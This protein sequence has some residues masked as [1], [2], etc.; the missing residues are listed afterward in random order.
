MRRSILA[1]AAAGLFA[2]APVRLGAAAPRTVTIHTADGRSVNALLFDADAHPAAAVV[3]VPMYGRTKEDWQAVGQRLSEANVTAL[4]LDLPAIGAPDDQRAVS[5]W[6]ADVRA[7]I[8]LLA[9]MPDVR[10]SAIGVLGASHGATIAALEA[11]GDTRVRAL[12]LVS[13]S[14]DYRGLRIESAMRQYGKRPALLVASSHDPYAA[15]SSRELAKDAPGPRELQ[16]SDVT[17][18]GTLLL[19]QDGDLV[20]AIVDWFRRTLG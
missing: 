18:H 2:I 12:A 15:R 3:L 8:D 1:V 20:R 17:A 16:M 14:L 19:S 13:P 11:G 7:A 6:T 4:A 5:T 10:A 9:A